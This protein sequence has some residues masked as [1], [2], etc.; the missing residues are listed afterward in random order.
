VIR[1]GIDEAG[2]GPVLGPLVIGAAAFRPADGDGDDLRARLKGLLCR[3]S[4]GKV[5]GRAP[6]P[7]PVDDSKAVYGRLGFEG[8]VAGVCACVAAAGH[9]PPAHLADWLERFADRGPSAFEGEPW[10]VRPHEEPV[11]VPT[12]PAG[13]RERTRLRG[14]E[15]LGV[16]VSPVTPRELNEVVA[17]TGNK[18]RALFLA[19]VALLVRVL[20]RWPGE[21][22][23]AVLDREGGRLD[24]GAYL[25]DAF[26][27]HDVTREP[28]PKDTAQ[29]SFRQDGRTVRLRFVTR[30]DSEDLPT[31]LASM[32]AKMTRELFMARLN[33]WFTSRQPGLR[34]TAGYVPD[35]HR[36]LSD[37]KPV[38]ERERL[39]LRVL[40]RDR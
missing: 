32:A 37:A 40:V 27:Y 14:V 18:A 34:P 4:A 5:R 11:P 25:A 15:F 2:Y 28:S 6:L 38:I 20:E 13:L 33:A 23:T 21:D 36:F 19:T 9:E 39:D 1:V 26:P 8:L 30:G 7:A 22:V 29:Y 3:A 10:F 31:G 16:E 35:G 12:F 24:Y 17:T